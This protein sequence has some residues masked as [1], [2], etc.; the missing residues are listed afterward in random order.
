AQ[1]SVGCGQGAAKG[2]VGT[3]SLLLGEKALNRLVE[4][5]AQ[6]ALE[7]FNRDEAFARQ[8]GP[9][10]QMESMDG[11][12]KK[13]GANALVEIVAAAAK[14][15]QILAGRLQLFKRKRLAHCVK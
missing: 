8:L 12:E 5:A 10:R 9:G 1:P 6:Q 3:V 7:S 4:T 15:F 2:I 13:Q 14:R 11:I